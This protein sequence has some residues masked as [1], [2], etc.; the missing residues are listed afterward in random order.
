MWFGNLTLQ[1]P[2]RNTN[3]IE[4]EITKIKSQLL[5][6]HSTPLLPPWAPSQHSGA[7]H[8]SPSSPQ[9]P[10]LYHWSQTEPSRHK[11][12]MNSEFHSWNHS[13]PCNS[14]L[15]Q[16]SITV[17][18]PELLDTFLEPYLCQTAIFL[19]NN[20]HLTTHSHSVGLYHLSPTGYSSLSTCDP[21]SWPPVM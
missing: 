15:R 10:S 4:M 13:P 8:H 19:S 2:I 1:Q 17:S 6:F 12:N 20:G 11:S 5:T 9:P 21:N 3:N 14:N 18:K 16:L 7:P